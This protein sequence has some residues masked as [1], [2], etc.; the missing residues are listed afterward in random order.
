MRNGIVLLLLQVMISPVL[1]A[2]NVGVGTTTPSEK[3]DVNGAVKVGNTS[4]VYAPGAIKYDGSELKGNEAGVWKSLVSSGT[5]FSFGTFTSTVRN[6][7][8]PTNDSF[9][10]T[11]AGQYLV[12]L[13][14]YMSNTQNYSG[15]VFDTHGYIYLNR[16][17]SHIYS[18]HAAAN[19]MEIYEGGYTYSMVPAEW[20]EIAT[21][22]FDT[23][24]VIKASALF[25][26]Y[27]TPLPTSSW[28]FSMNVIL[29]KLQ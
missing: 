6:Q 10:V 2:Q 22:Y 24:D 12:I 8:V 7:E 13:T 26:T 27:G 16:K 19:S 14:S 18:H 4:T 5:T 29:V 1:L 9:V 21:V 17:G 11:D 25:T 20:P 23:G 3:L 15:S 28:S